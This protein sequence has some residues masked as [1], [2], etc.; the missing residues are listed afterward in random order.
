HPFHML[1]QRRGRRPQGL[2]A[3][4]ELVNRRFRRRFRRRP[5]GRRP[6]VRGRSRVPRVPPCPPAVLTGRT[7]AAS[8]LS[9]H[10]ITGGSGFPEVGKVRC[11]KP[12]TVVLV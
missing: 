5:R 1:T 12:P 11:K 7:L 4:E 6:L 8:G 9:S 3:G 2:G 10:E